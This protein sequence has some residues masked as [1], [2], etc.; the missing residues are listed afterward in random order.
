MNI[1]IYFKASSQHD[2]TGLILSTI[3]GDKSSKKQPTDKETKIVNGIISPTK[4]ISQNS[5]N[6][7]SLHLIPIDI[8]NIDPKS[9]NASSEEII[10]L[11]SSD[12]SPQD[13]SPKEI[14]LCEED[15]IIEINLELSA[16]SIENQANNLEIST[17]IQ[18]C[19]NNENQNHINI[20]EKLKKDPEMQKQ[21]Q[22]F[23]I[24]FNL[25]ISFSLNNKLPVDLV[26]LI[27]T[28][29]T[30]KQV[31]IDVNEYKENGTK[32]KGQQELYN[33]LIQKGAMIIENGIVFIHPERFKLAWQQI[34]EEETLKKLLPY[35]ARK[36]KFIEGFFARMNKDQTLAA[37]QDLKTENQDLKT[38]NQDL[39][40]KEKDNQNLI[41]S[42]IQSAE[43]VAIL[44]EDYEKQQEEI[45][46]GKETIEK[47]QKE[48]Q[49]QKE[50]IQ[51]LEMQLDIHFKK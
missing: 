8:P 45:E 15:K 41:N 34:F 50:Y 32:P 47:L 5:Q 40:N 25:P 4:K 37:N 48:N 38:E 7:T 1:G 36:F 28:Q 13:S 17:E 22:E 44:L 3:N 51:N 33:K 6:I 39:K 23:C 16:D 19:E 26:A 35:E 9:K 10:L 30:K 18:L 11:S 21:F 46:M 12:M 49:T 42:A 43:D 14:I 29:Q 20:L 24:K 2:Q 27:G 31:P